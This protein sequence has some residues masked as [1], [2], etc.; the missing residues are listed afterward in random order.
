MVRGRELRP[1]GIFIGR[2]ALV[3]DDEKIPRDLV[4]SLLHQLGFEQV[5]EATD[6]SEALKKLD[7]SR[8]D[9]ILCDIMMKP[10]DGIEFART[11]RKSARLR[12]DAHKAAT[13]IVFLTGSSEKEHILAAK[14]LKIH[15]YLLK[16]VKPDALQSK[17]IKV[18]GG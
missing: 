6:G 11:L 15:G 1:S 4:I 3:I 17:L 7:K 5:D 16:P 12:F 18:F 9:L 10:M 8:Y 14:G 2:N 13:P